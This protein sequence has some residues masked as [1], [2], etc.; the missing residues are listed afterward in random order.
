[1]KEVRKEAQKAI[2]PLLKEIEGK[3]IRA[4]LDGMSNGLEKARKIY[5]E[6][7]D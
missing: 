3:L 5:N 4:Y 2:K 6:P 1:M 7:R